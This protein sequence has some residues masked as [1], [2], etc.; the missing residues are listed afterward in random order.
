MLAR[1]LELADRQEL[2]LECHFYRY[3]HDKN[4]NLRQ[5]SLS[6]IRELINSGVR[7]PGWDLQKNVNRAT[8]DGHPQPQFLQT[9]A[10]VISDELDVKELERYDEW[11]CA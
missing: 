2:I 3:A 8:N 10:K 9:L 6:R 4:E 1:A 5:E 7:S 11:R